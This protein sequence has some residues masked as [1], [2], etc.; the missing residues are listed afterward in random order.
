VSKVQFGD[1]SET[2]QYKLWMAI[3]HALL[4]VLGAVEEYLGMER[5]VK[6]RRKR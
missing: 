4:I 6:P 2:K 3:R 1:V 5:S